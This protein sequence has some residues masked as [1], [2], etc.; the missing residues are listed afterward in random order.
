M[1]E[2]NST[3][4][5]SMESSERD[6][7]VVIE[8]EKASSLKKPRSSMLSRNNQLESEEEVSV[9]EDEQVHLKPSAVTQQDEAGSQADSEEGGNNIGVDFVSV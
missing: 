9:S 3:E 8:I 6:E 5:T 2:G 1:Y 4:G 7:S